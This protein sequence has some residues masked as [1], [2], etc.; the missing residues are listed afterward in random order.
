M[1]ARSHTQA[2]VHKLKAIRDPAMRT[3]LAGAFLRD[4]PGDDVVATL[5]QLVGEVRG[6]HDPAAHSLVDAITAALGELDYD[7]R[8]RLYSAAKAAGHDEVARLLFDASPGPDRDD[9]DRILSPERQVVPRGRILTLGERKA[10]ARTNRRDL[11][12]HVV[13]DP[14]PDVVSIF[15]DNPHVIE[16]DVVAVAAGRA[17]HPDALAAVAAHP[18]WRVRVAI[19]RALVMNPSTPLHLAVRLLVDLRAIDLRAIAADPKLNQELRAQATA[20]IRE[21]G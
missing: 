16:A 20:L 5:H 9:L 17:A 2:L 7:T 19:R 12:L 6:S 4:Q 14:H 10:L 18:R 11:I 15:L 1:V 21:P 3:A 8:A 13:R